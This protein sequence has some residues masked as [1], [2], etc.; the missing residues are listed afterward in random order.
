[1]PADEPSPFLGE[2]AKETLPTKK[3]PT[4]NKGIRFFNSFSRFKKFFHNPFHTTSIVPVTIFTGYLGSGKTT[5]IINLMKKMPDGYKIAWLKN[6]MGNTQ[7]DTE[8]TDSKHTSSVKEVLQGCICHVMIGSLQTSLDELLASNPDRIIIET[9][10]S[11]TPAPIVWE[12]RKNPRLRVDG[13]ITVIDAVNFSG[14][15]NKSITLK[16]QAKYTDLILINKHEGLDESALE[17]R[18]NDL[19]EINLDTPK[20]KTDHGNI[21]P[22]LVF[23]LDSKLF[24]TQKSLE[25][26]E[27]GV[28]KAHQDL[29]VDLL[30]LKPAQSYDSALLQK[31]LEQLPKQHFYR[32]KGVLRTP[33]GPVVLDCAFGAC[34]LT[35]VSAL[36][37]EVRVVC[38]GEDL[39]SFKPT[40]AEI[41]AIPEE[42]IRFTPKH[43]HTHSTDSK[44]I[45]K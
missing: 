26:E 45:G 35:P 39:S 44:N 12:I 19:Y 11:A 16:L 9:S 37:G 7:V 1:M 14:Y 2:T 15:I 10:G 20:I 6:E 34:T 8:L 24:L 17:D 40:I 13:V 29:E 43:H 23:G 42:T 21:S 36:R 33:K 30:E 3:S 38:M 27:E 31:N 25:L 4:P 32:V 22:D 5:V 18:L 28:S 41:F